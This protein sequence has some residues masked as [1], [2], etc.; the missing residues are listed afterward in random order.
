MYNLNYTP[1]IWWYKVEE[2]LYLGVREPKRLNTIAVGYSPCIHLK[3]LTK[4]RKGL[5]QRNQQHDR[6]FDPVPSVYKVRMLT[7]C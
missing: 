7:L 4:I 5:G 2:K 6:D 1:N 3:G